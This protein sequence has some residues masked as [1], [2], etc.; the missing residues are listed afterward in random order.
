MTANGDK[1]A[2]FSELFLILGEAGQITLE[3]S[4]PT[5]E[6]ELVAKFSATAGQVQVHVESAAV[7]LVRNGESLTRAEILENGDRLRAGDLVLNF[8]AHGRGGI[9]Y[10]QAVDENATLPPAGDE[11]HE[12]K[13]WFLVASSDGEISGSK[14]VRKPVMDDSGRTISP[15]EYVKSEDVSDRKKP[16]PVI[17]LAITAVF[18]VLGLVAGFMFSA[19]AVRVVV[20]PVPD[21]IEV[22]GAW[23]SLELGGHYLLLPGEA[24]VSATKSGYY[25]FQQAFAVDR[26][27]N[28]EVSFQ[29]T[30]LP[31]LYEIHSKPA[32]SAL[33]HVDGEPMGQTPLTELALSSGE[34]ELLVTADRFLDHLEIVQ[35]EGGGS[36]KALTVQLEPAWANVELITEPVGAQVFIDDE[37]IGDTPMIVEMLQGFRQLKISKTG[38]KNWQENIRIVAGENQRLPVTLVKADGKVVIRTDPPGASVTINKRYRGRTPLNIAL[39]PDRDYQLSFSLSGYEKAT[40]NISVRSDQDGSV[41]VNMRVLLGRVDIRSEPTGATV[42]IDG[43]ERGV[44]NLLLELSAQ[45]HLVE[46]SKPGYAPYHARVTPRPGFDQQIVGRLK[47]LEQARW[48]SIPT[49]I[50]TGLGQSMKLVRSGSLNMGAP[51]RQQGRRANEIQHPVKLTRAFYF[52]THEVKNADYRRF[53]L[54]H[55]SGAVKSTSL[56]QGTHP[57][58]Q[59]SWQ[60]AANFCNWLSK[61]DG[62][63]AAYTKKDGKMVAVSPMNTGYRL[64]SEAE[65]AFVQRV[66]GGEVRDMYP[67]GD[68]LPPTAGAGNF[69][70]VSARSVL[71]AVIGAYDDKY[72]ATAPVGHFDASGAGFYDLAG[73]VSEWTHDYYSA[74]PLVVGKLSVDP[75][76]SDSG[77]YHVVRGSSWTSGNITE[78]RVSFRDYGSDPRHDLGFRLARYLE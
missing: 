5:G 40:R 56:N 16:L 38:F 34:H 20:D 45:P 73:N 41:L 3:S 14:D 59:I 12:G 63:P 71:S 39:A 57:V 46:F 36:R 28:Q 61:K 8:V 31:D 15:G 68:T 26:V 67:W 47:T 21:N 52:G 75:L 70:D 2:G 66:S 35:V 58:V 44:S 50:K 51:R 7:P 1:A 37:K 25:P 32:T 53:K 27:A 60:D 42:K 23:F 49:T 77:E 17:P 65:W 72:L 78:L 9:F 18:V 24:S 19:T 22:D 6:H 76:G 54:D 64:P 33:V 55:D 69:A 13:A 43:V 4:L 48:D 74:D 29:L 30:R 10:Q 11:V 62:L